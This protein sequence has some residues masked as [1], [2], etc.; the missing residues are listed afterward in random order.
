M[1]QGTIIINFAGNSI[2]AKVLLTRQT[3]SEH[4]NKGFDMERRLSISRKWSKIGFVA[5][6]GTSYTPRDY[7]FIDTKTR[8]VRT[9][10]YRLKQL[11]TNGSFIYS[12][13][14]SVKK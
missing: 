7:S 13:E 14:V 12:S 5:G 8:K 10:I 6:A 1:P 2:S 4:N 9:Y 11:N 3:A